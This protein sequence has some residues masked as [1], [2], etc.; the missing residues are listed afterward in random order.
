VAERHAQ[1]SAQLEEQAKSQAAMQAYLEVTHRVVVAAVAAVTSRC[2]SG[3]ALRRWVT[4]VLRA[5]AHAVDDADAASTVPWSRVSSHTRR[6]PCAACGVPYAAATHVPH[7][8]TGVPNTVAGGVRAR[9]CVDSA[10]GHDARVVAR[11]CGMARRC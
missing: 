4:A 5:C 6:L 9:V 3:R 1:I 2:D 8:A 11:R 7:A 10:C